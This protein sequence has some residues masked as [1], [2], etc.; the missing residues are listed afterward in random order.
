MDHGFG[1]DEPEGR[2]QGSDTY[3]IGPEIR[4]GAAE[5]GSHQGAIHPVIGDVAGR[6]RERLGQSLSAADTMRRIGYG[7]PPSHDGSAANT[8]GRPFRQY[9]G[10]TQVAA[11][12]VIDARH[13]SH[14]GMELAGDEKG[15]HRN[16]G[17]LGPNV[18]RM[19]SCTLTRG[20]HCS[21]VCA[22]VQSHGHSGVIDLTR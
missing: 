11:K 18:R 13:P 15:L 5:L 6:G 9:G 4:D 2:K 16:Y 22:A 12:V 21:L 7:C 3:R 20:V 17:S 8:S 1:G 10:V 19:P 14:Q